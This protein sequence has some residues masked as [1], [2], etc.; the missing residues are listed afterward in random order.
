[1]PE[2]EDKASYSYWTYDDDYP[3][4]SNAAIIVAGGCN[5]GKSYFTYN[6][7]VPAYVKYGG[8]K[9]LLI[10]SRTGSF[11]F[12]TATALKKPIYKNIGIEYLKIEQV[13][14]KCQLIRSDA[15]INSYLVKM[16]KIRSV[17]ELAELAKELQKLIKNVSDFQ[18]IHM[19]L[20]KL[21]NI[22]S[23]FMTIEMEEVREYAE[24]LYKRGT[25]LTYN[26]ILV[27]MDDYGGCREFM[28]PSSELHKLVYNHRHLHL[29]LV[30]LLQSITSIST[31]IRRNVNIFVCFSTLSDMDIQ[32]LRDRLP[33]KWNIKKLREEFFKIADADDRDDKVLTLFCTF[34]FQ[35]IVIGTKPCLLS[36]SSNDSK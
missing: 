36:L 33:L 28:T 13:Y 26:P 17:D 19:E 22:I 6:Y 31:N 35:K 11:D 32:L 1:M 8:I 20:T 2:E 14:E 10:A 16:M 21:L 15:I 30:M 23:K 4:N 3:L 5:S 18:I 34:P 7:I 27:I 29:T 9:T 24:L 25:Q 12:T